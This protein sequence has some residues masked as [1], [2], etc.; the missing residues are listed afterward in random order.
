MLTAFIITCVRLLFRFPF[1]PT[2]RFT[3]LN[4]FVGSYLTGLSVWGVSQT[5]VQRFLSSK[6]LFHARMSVF[7][8]LPLLIALI[9]ICGLQGLVMYAFYYGENPVDGSIRGPP[10]TTSAD[11][12]TVY[13]VSEQFGGIPGFQG[14]YISCL[15]AGSLSTISSNLNAL[16]S[17]TLVDIIRPYRH[18]RSTRRGDLLAEESELRD[19]RLSKILVAVYGFL[20]LALSYLCLSMGTLISLFNTVFGA[21]GGPLLGSFGLGMLWKRANTHGVL[22]GSI[23]GFLL[24]VVAI[25]GSRFQAG[26]SQM[27][28][29]FKLSFQ[30]YALMT[31]STTVIVSI[32]MSEFFRRLDPDLN[33]TDIDPKLL[34]TFLRKEE[35]ATKAKA[36]FEMI[37]SRDST[38]KANEGK[39]I[40]DGGKTS[41]IM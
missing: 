11:Q 15:V 40:E 10:N 37:C 32:I 12:I 24:G 33:I 36:D 41:D 39:L 31:L 7:I 34:A 17:V 38:E 22:S 1:D 21:V 35:K 19:T 28:G 3:F 29:L 30:W 4:L 20:G 26:H 8:Q 9:L 25:L 16:S 6:S 14:L 13:F 23:S 18:W 2:E 5:S 27:F